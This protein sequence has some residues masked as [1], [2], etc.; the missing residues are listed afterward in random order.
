VLLGILDHFAIGVLLVDQRGSVLHANTA[1][2]A[3]LD[4]GLRLDADWASDTFPF[5]RVKGCIRSV[6]SKATCR[7]LTL[8]SNASDRPMFVM[9]TPIDCRATE[10]S[11][12]ASWPSQ[13]ALVILCDLGRPASLPATSMAEA[14][15]LTGAE[16]RVAEAA[17]GGAG[18]G[19][20]AHQLGLSPNTVKTHLR[21][22]YEKTGTKRRAE[23]ARVMAMVGFAR[24][25]A[26]DNCLQT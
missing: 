23:L 25:S 26:T 16:V 21:R 14:Y 4:G 24:A 9:V 11:L 5:G 13:A 17:S 20:I 7:A 22:I 12:D 8:R 3:L 15:G 10:S 6:I 2:R 19:E 18:I 1:A